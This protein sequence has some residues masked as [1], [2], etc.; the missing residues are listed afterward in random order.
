MVSS[1][2]YNNKALVETPYSLLPN[3][4]TVKGIQRVTN[5]FDYWAIDWKSWPTLIKE[6]IPN[7]FNKLILEREKSLVSNDLITKFMLQA[8]IIC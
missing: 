7:N 3:A 8:P 1:T 4:H 2:S 5:I 6:C